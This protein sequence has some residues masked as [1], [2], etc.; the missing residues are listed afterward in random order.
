MAEIRTIKA[1]LDAL[2]KLSTA[3][4]WDLKGS[5]GGLRR[6]LQPAFSSSPFHE[7]A[8][9]LIFGQ[10]R[11]QEGEATEQTA[12]AVSGG[13]SIHSG[14]SGG[15]GDGGGDGGGRSVDALPSKLEPLNVPEQLDYVRDLLVKEAMR[16]NEMLERVA[17]LQTDSV[18]GRMAASRLARGQES[19]RRVEAQQRS[20]QQGGQVTGEQPLMPAVQVESGPAEDGRNKESPSGVVASTAAAVELLEILRKRPGLL[21]E[22]SH[23]GREAAVVGF[24]NDQGLQE[25]D[26]IFDQKTFKFK[27]RG[28]QAVSELSKQLNLKPFEAEWLI[29]QLEEA[30]I[31]KHPWKAGIQTAST[32]LGPVKDVVGVAKDVMGMGKSGADDGK[33]GQ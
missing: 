9:R 16:R 3:K 6:D 33:E 20:Q 11:K 8:A 31:A 19:V 28:T 1:T 24:C 26:E 5:H 12:G 30:F 15:G 29:E 10:V 18:A 14:G 25:L 27:A 2:L 23:P 7:M 22:S 21:D 32:F 13:T 4:W 17:K